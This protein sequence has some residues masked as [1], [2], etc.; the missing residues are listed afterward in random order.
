MSTKRLDLN[1]R[2]GRVSGPMVYADVVVGGVVIPR[3]LVG[4]AHRVEVPLLTRVAW[5]GIMG[6]GF[7][8]RRVRRQGITPVF[9][10]LMQTRALTGRGLANQFG[11]RLGA[12]GG[13][14]TFGG[15]DCA[16][17]G[18]TGKRCDHRFSF[19]HVDGDG[20]WSVKLLG[21]EARYKNRTER[22][23]CPTAGC[24]AI[25]DTGTYLSY[26][27]AKDIRS[28][29]PARLGHCGETA[30]L[31]EVVFTL[32]GTGSGAPVKL[33][34]RPDDYV[35]R[36]KVGSREDCAVGVAGDHGDGWTIGQGLLSKFYTLFDRDN[37]RVGF[38]ELPSKQAHAASLA[39]TATEVDIDADADEDADEEGLDEDAE[40]ME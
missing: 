6:L 31:P 22:V 20:Y 33:T 34:V 36:Q 23:S 7:P 25:V 18:E 39:E 32:A 5:D 29:L 3:Q 4:T 27:P 40:D 16:A 9:D 21:V 26:G 37:F 38:A 35:L 19:A 2:S 13:A 24:K 8:T 1:Y 10:T 12:D 14:L 30:A 28:L 15:A 17:L 11:Y